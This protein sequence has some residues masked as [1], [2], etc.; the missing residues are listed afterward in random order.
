[1]SSPERMEPDGLVPSGPGADDGA[2]QESGVPEFGALLG[3]DYGSRRV[4]VAISS[5]DQSI[6][7]PLETYTR[8]TPELDSVWL[9]Q[10][11]RGYGARGLVVGLPVHMSGDEGGK[12]R[13]ARQ[14]GEWAAT[15]T[16]LPVTW[17]DERYS[18]AVADMYL[19]AGGL[20]KK[21][22][23]AGRDRLAA[24]VILQSFLDSADRNA[25]PPSLTDDGE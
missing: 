17:W 16:G 20:S 15:V 5:E 12:A 21:K 8:R 2:G 1:M 14:Y 18:S 6:A 3:I 9:R 22:R 24:Q 13:E 23:K 4:G 7:C 19:H 25:P 10:L 11:A